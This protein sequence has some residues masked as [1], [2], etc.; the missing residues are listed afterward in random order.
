MGTE[1][2][3]STLGLV[4]IGNTGSRSAAIARGFGMRVL[5]VDPLLTADEIVRRGAEPVDMADD[6]GRGRHHLGAL[7]ARQHHGQ[8]VRR[9][10][11]SPP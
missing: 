10:P 2:S 5:A 3:G 9:A 11:N 6:A 8:H 1:I 4:G 7:S